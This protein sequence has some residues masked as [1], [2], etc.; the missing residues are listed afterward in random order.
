MKNFE[1]AFFDGFKQ[2]VGRAV[3]GNLEIN[4]D[5]NLRMESVNSQL[6]GLLGYRQFELLGRSLKHVLS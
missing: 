6:V 2:K 3:G 4:L 5:R 1:T